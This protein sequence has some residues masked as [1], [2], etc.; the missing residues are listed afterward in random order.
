MNHVVQDY[1]DKSEGEVALS[2]EDVEQ[3]AH[4]IIW[5]ME[6]DG[7]TPDII[8][9][10]ARSGLIPAALISYAVGNKE[11]YTIKI[12]FS[13]VQKEGKDQELRHKPKISQ[14]L[15]KDIEGLKVLVVD[16]MVVSGSTLKLVGDYLEMKHPAEV[17]FVVLYKQPW[18]QF[19]PDYFGEETRQ[20]PIFPWKRLVNNN[21]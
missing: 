19:E 10:I 5:R 11:L 6:R 17:K 3:A 2:W 15:S 7:F 9:S 8:I 21:K 16:E 14:E 18:T 4:N 12:D 13:K 1:Y 20:W